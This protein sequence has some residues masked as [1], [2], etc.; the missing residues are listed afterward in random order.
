MARPFSKLGELES[1]RE[2]ASRRLSQ[3]AEESGQDSSLYRRCRELWHRREEDAFAS[4]FHG[5]FDNARVILERGLHALTHGP[6]VLKKDGLAL[7]DALR[8][9]EAC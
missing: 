1:T 9:M 3:I 7:E 5:D 8:L 6:D 4:I 2:R